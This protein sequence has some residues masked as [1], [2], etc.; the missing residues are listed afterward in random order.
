MRRK[1]NL[2]KIKKMKS[3]NA[4]DT[5]PMVIENDTI[6]S[7]D[8]SFTG[9]LDL[10]SYFHVKKIK[11]KAF[12]DCVLKFIR[13]P[14]SLVKI[15][16]QAFYGSRLMGIEFN[17]RLCEIG[18]GAFQNCF[19]LKCSIELPAGLRRLSGMAF[20][21]SSVQSVI[22][23]HGLYE[24]ESD[25][26]AYC[27]D[28]ETITFPPTLK[29]IGYRAFSYCRRLREVKFPETLTAIA[30]YAFE[31][32]PEID[33]Y[34]PSSISIGSKAFMHCRSLVY[35][36]HESYFDIIADHQLNT[37]SSG[38][39][40]AY[41]C[42]KL[43]DIYPILSKIAPNVVLG[44]N[45]YIG[46]TVVSLQGLCITALARKHS[47][48]VPALPRI[49]IGPKCLLVQDIHIGVNDELNAELDRLAL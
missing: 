38:V 37:K 48:Y 49:L 7:C 27:H 35:R 32:N 34:L 17:D 10:R 30:A 24:I 41:I 45:R 4:N 31:H 16:N 20:Y 6:I 43:V 3:Y 23:N 15:G 12:H 28:L 21:K 5:Y 1:C 44:I 47:D 22:I 19:N 46:H 33:F 25:V 13:L 36:S 14:P 2:T 26:F 39:F 40:H 8:K 42:N 29:K 18:I 11:D 9:I